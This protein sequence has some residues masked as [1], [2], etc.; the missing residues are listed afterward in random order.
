MIVETIV[1]KGRIFDRM[2]VEYNFGLKQLVW[3][4]RK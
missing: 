3:V 4:E 1:V 2:W